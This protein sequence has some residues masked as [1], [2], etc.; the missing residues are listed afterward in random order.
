MVFFQRNDLVLE[1]V[2]GDSCDYPIG[3][4]RISGVSSPKKCVWASACEGG[5]RSHCR[6]HRQRGPVYTAIWA[7]E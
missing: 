2:Q 1:Y 7:C 6:K 5:W 3:V 4:V